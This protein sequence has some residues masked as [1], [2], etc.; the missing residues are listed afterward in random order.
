MRGIF[1]GIITV[2]ALLVFIG[3]CVWAFYP[4]NKK[5]FE[6]DAK[7]PFNED[8]VDSKDSDNKEA[9][10][11]TKASCNNQEKKTNE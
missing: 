1:H 10:K 6:K 2:I 11:L 5:G 9:N 3:L 7:I 8:S 4:R